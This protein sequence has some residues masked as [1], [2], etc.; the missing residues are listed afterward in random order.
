MKL[1]PIHQWQGPL[2]LSPIQKEKKG[3]GRE[4]IG[5]LTCSKVND[6]VN[7]EDCVAKAVEGDPFSAEVIVEE[8]YRHWQDDQIGHQQEQHTKIPVESK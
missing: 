3:R 1:L 2:F 4:G 5:L 8:R 7:H 6:N